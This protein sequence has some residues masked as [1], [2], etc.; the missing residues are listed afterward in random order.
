[1]YLL[2]K[3][4]GYSCYGNGDINSDIENAKL[5]ASDYHVERFSKSGIST[6]NSEVPDTAGRKTKKKRRRT[7]AVT[8][9]YTLHANAIILAL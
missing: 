8:K 2:A 7:Q 1:M 4:G 9:R 5:T 3:F 6:Y